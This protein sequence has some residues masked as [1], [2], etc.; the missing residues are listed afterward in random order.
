MLRVT[1][2]AVQVGS[3]LA[4]V[5]QVVLSAAVAAVSA[6]VAY[7][8]RAALAAGAPCLRLGADTLLR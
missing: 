5:A 6:A 2:T 4:Q 7:Q 3:S 8:V 1:C